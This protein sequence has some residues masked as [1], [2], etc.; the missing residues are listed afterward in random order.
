[1]NL[2]WGLADKNDR[3]QVQTLTDAQGRFTKL[4]AATGPDYGRIP[5]FRLLSAIRR[6][7]GEGT[8]DNRWKVPSLG[9]FAS[10]FLNTD[11]SWGHDTKVSFTSNATINQRQLGY[12]Y[13]W[14]S[15]RF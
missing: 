5:D 1:M 15:V 11:T 3:I 6:I 2:Q 7:A 13:L 8:G 14:V 10:V 12:C 9:H 4:R